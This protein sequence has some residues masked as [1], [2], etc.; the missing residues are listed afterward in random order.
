MAENR[1]HASFEHALTQMPRLNEKLSGAYLSSRERG[2]VTAMRLLHRV[3]RNNVALLGDA[4]GGVDA[5]T[6][7]GLRMAFR[8]ALALAD[9][10]ANGELSQY[11]RAHR[12]LASRPILMGNLLLWLGSN[13]RIRARVI[14]AMQRRPELFARILSA[15]VGD[16][17]PAQLLSAGASLGWQ[18][19]A[20]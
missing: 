4:S 3:Y 10:M 15:H 20:A 19:L 11:Q 6:G 14:C 18:L 17:T 16:A 1:R 9:A 2:A 13:P 12:Q 8:Q 5:I 7:E